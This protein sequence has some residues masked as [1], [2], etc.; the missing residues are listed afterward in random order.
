M[1]FN[2][3]ILIFVLQLTVINSKKHNKNEYKK[4]N[5]TTT[6]ESPKP[7]EPLNMFALMQLELRRRNGLHVKN[8][9]DTLPCPPA[10][11]HCD[12]DGKKYEA[13]TSLGSEGPNCWIPPTEPKTNPDLFLRKDVELKWQCRKSLQCQNEGGVDIQQC[14]YGSN[15]GYRRIKDCQPK[16]HACIYFGKTFIVAE[17]FAPNCWRDPSFFLG[18]WSCFYNR[19][20]E[21]CPSDTVDISTECV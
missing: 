17:K 20:G 6:I 1:I 19:V 7:I 9:Y 4:A 11:Q 21:P 13:M 12:F 16:I 2:K 10:T 15:N 3:L 8:I 5:D 18:E 14:Q